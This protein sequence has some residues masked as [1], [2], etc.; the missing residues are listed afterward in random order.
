MPNYK[1]ISPAEFKQAVEN[2][3][4]ARVIDCRT[5]PELMEFKLE[6]H[7]HID[8]MTP[9]FGEILAKLDKSLAYYIYCR[10]G[11][12]SGFLCDYMSRLGF[13]ELYN[14]KGGIIAWKNTFK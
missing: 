14:L 11:N 2:K 9:A 13:K 10:S 3:P 12:R 7:Y 1:D 4:T 8:I 5:A 6:H